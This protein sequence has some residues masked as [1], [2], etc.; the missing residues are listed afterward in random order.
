MSGAKSIKVFGTKGGA[1]QKNKGI[2][3]QKGG[4]VLEDCDGKMGDEYN[5]CVEKVEVKYAQKEREER[6]NELQQIRNKT[7]SL[8]SEEKA[9]EWTSKWGTTQDEAVEGEAVEGEA[10]EGGKDCRNN[11]SKRLSSSKGCAKSAQRG[12]GPVAST[13][14]IQMGGRSRVVYKGPRG[15]AYIKQGG[16]FVSLKSLKSK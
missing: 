3:K 1:Q 2:K 9:D 13:E 12:C 7:Q 15:G 4:D 8:P 5:A 10:A 16:E 6:E 11:M 14:R